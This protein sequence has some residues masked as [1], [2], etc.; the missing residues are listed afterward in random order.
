MIIKNKIIKFV[1]K[2]KENQWCIYFLIYR[3]KIVYIGITNNIHRRIQEHANDKIERQTLI[4]G[5]KFDSY[6]YIKCKYKKTAL[7][8]EGKLIKKIKTKYNTTPTNSTH[9]YIKK[10]DKNKNCYIKE[11]VT[12]KQYNKFYANRYLY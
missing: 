9:N 8:Y 2:P 12:R 3:K 5:K 11:I 7:K 1:F 4:V 6:K 10:F